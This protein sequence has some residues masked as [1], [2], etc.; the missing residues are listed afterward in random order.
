[1][2]VRACVHFFISC[3][4]Y[5][6]L[7]YSGLFLPTYPRRARTLYHMAL[8]GLSFCHSFS[9]HSASLFLT[10]L[11]L[12]LFGLVRTFIGPSAVLCLVF[13]LSLLSQHF[14]IHE[15]HSFSLLF[16]FTHRLFF[17]ES[18]YSMASFSGVYLSCPTFLLSLLIHTPSFFTCDLFH[19]GIRNLIELFG[20]MKCPSKSSTLRLLGI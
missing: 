13:H 19:R 8:V 15:H 17:S 2:C 6:F 12:F 5:S 7:L 1:M 9:P 4:H 20:L 18:S 16:Y 10:T 14:T 11:I 3:C